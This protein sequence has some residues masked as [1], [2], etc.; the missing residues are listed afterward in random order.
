MHQKLP[1]ETV[2]SI[3]KQTHF[4]VLSF[5]ATSKR[6]EPLLGTYW[7]LCWTKTSSMYCIS[8]PHKSISGTQKCPEDSAIS[9]PSVA[10]W[11]RA[12]KTSLIV[13]PGTSS[14]LGR[15]PSALAMFPITVHESLA[16]SKGRAWT[17]TR[18]EVVLKSLAEE[19][20]WKAAPKAVHLSQ[21]ILFLPHP[22]LSVSQVCYPSLASALVGGG[23]ILPPPS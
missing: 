16:L 1:L 19:L 6:E 18:L 7:N 9:F 11:M 3:F 22:Q 20:K 23:K 5:L 15:A 10:Q 12:T 13:W 14:R 4:S 2:F 8:F 17:E 21:S